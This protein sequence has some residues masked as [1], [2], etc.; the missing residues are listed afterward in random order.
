MYVLSSENVHVSN[1]DGIEKDNSATF[2]VDRDKVTQSSTK[3][4]Q[5]HI[6]G[7]IGIS[8]ILE[9]LVSILLSRMRNI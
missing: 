2:T 4:T 1:L 9:Y 6:T 7:I 8:W 3:H 5:K